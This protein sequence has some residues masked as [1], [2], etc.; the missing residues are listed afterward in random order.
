MSSTP[1]PT[2]F[3]VRYFFLTQGQD[4]YPN[5]IVRAS[6]QVYVCVLVKYGF[7]FFVAMKQVV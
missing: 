2:I 3:Q 6:I 5:A 1:T 4:I 7:T